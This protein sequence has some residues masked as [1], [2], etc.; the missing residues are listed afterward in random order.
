LRSPF[1]IDFILRKKNKKQKDYEI[2]D[3]CLEHHCDCNHS[4]FKSTIKHTLNIIIFITIITFLLN[5][6]IHYLGEERPW[7]KGT[8]HK[9][10]KDYFKY[11]NKTE[12]KNTELETGWELYFVLYKMFLV[13]LKP[14]PYI[15]YKI[16]DFLIP[17]F[18]K[19]RAKKVKERSK[20][21]G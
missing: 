12:W 5:I 4:I 16:I 2:K 3:F 13:I 14:F 10:K 7:R 9:Y 8:T 21:N 19:I 15:R 6:G 1:I 17:L 11:L 20:E 18:M